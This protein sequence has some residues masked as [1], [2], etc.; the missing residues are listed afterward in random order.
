MIEFINSAL[1]FDFV[2]ES[3]LPVAIRL[4][5]LGGC[6]FIID[7]VLE[8][9]NSLFKAGSIFRTLFTAIEVITVFIT[10]VLFGLVIFMVIIFPVLLSII[11]IKFYIIDIFALSKILAGIIS[12]V[13]CFSIIAILGIWV[14]KD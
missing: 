13:L 2:I 11:A 12:T 10:G 9:I 14:V 1:Q 6:V 7:V 5:I 8:G 3:Y 4:F